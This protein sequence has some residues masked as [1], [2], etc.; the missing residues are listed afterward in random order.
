[1]SPVLMYRTGATVRAA[2]NLMLDVCG[3]YAS[4]KHETPAFEDIPCRRLCIQT[5]LPL[6]PLARYVERGAKYAFT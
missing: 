5:A 3:R 2:H 4:E 1:M 6:G